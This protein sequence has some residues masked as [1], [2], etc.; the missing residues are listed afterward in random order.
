MSFLDKAKDMDEDIKDK[1]EDVVD[2][3]E[4]KLPEGV[5]EKLDAAKEKVGDLVDKIQDKLPG[6]KDDDASGTPAS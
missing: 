3:I 6:H 4:D 1:A 2:K 5:Q